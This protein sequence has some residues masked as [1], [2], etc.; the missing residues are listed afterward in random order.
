M[1]ELAATLM[2]FSPSRHPRDLPPYDHARL[3]ECFTELDVVLRELLETA[4]PTNCVTLRLEPGDHSVHSTS[5]D[6]DR[7]LSAVQ[8]YL[9]VTSEMDQSRLIQKAPDWIKVAS[10]D[11]IRDLLSQALPGVTLRHQPTPP[12]AVP[13]KM[14]CQYFHLETTGPRWAAILQSRSVAAWVAADIPDAGLELVLLLPPE[15]D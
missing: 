4:I 5:L 15:R 10:R 14:G 13:L 8:A 9:A 2:T 7:H 11:Q 1:V 3:S 6:D 12:A